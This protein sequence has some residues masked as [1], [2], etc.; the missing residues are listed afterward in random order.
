MT[1]VIKA[2][3]W[4]Q[5]RL[6][7]IDFIAQ[8]LDP[9]AWTYNADNH[10]AWALE[11]NRVD[12]PRGFGKQLLDRRAASF[13]QAIL[14]IEAVE[15]WHAMHTCMHLVH[16]EGFPESVPGPRCENCNRLRGY[17]LRKSDGAILDYR[18]KS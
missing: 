1:P 16:L 14:A 6:G 13:D 2:L 15:R 9:A 7:Q 17:V 10:I 4:R 3:Q 11:F 12:N 5:R 18:E 8:A